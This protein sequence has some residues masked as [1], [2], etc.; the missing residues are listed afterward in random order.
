[1]RVVR[2]GKTPYVRFDRNLYSI[3]HTHVRKPLTLFASATRVRILDQQTELARHPRSYD[4]GG[5]PN[6]AIS[7]QLKTGHFG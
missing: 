4:L 3:P 6:P 1:M 7:G 2:S 5:H